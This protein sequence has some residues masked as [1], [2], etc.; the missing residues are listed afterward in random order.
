MTEDREWERDPEDGNAEELPPF[1]EEDEEQQDLETEDQDAGQ[2]QDFAEG[3]SL[4][5]IVNDEACPQQYGERH[6][7]KIEH[8]V[9][10]HKPGQLPSI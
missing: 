7:N 9:C 3:S 6:E 8:S 5:Q 2:H 4:L 1:P 10:I